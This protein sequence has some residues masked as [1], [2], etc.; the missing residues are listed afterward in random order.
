MNEARKIFLHLAEVA[1]LCLFY[2]CKLLMEHLSGNFHMCLFDSY[3]HIK[4]VCEGVSWEN[5]SRAVHT[6]KCGQ[7]Q[8]MLI[9]PW[10]QGPQWPPRDNA[11][12]I[13]LPRSL[14]QGTDPRGQL[15]RY[16]R[17]RHETLITP[18]FRVTS[19]INGCVL[20]YPFIKPWI[21]HDNIIAHENRAQYFQV[22]PFVILTRNLILDSEF[23][24]SK[25]KF[26][27]ILFT[28]RVIKVGYHL[29]T[30]YSAR[31]GPNM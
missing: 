7:T 31:T 22:F 3:Y 26:I 11:I 15:T 30:K 1:L 29:H 4:Q 19:I 28:K 25:S 21:H 5:R 12:V 2:I 27:S 13:P 10:P 6:P 17:A 18:Q 24:S 9:A 23:E 16:S 20:V 8:H 14:S